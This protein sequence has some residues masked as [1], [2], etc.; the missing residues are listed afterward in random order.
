[1]QIILFGV[2]ACKESSIREYCI[3]IREL[4]YINPRLSS[5]NKVTTLRKE[6]LRT[7][8]NAASE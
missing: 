2:F 1:M 8:N 5:E 7:C 6:Q 3:L 4:G